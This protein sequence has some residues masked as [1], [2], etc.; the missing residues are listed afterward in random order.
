MSLNEENKEPETPSLEEGSK[1]EFNINELPEK[2]EKFGDI[3]LNVKVSLGKK[4]ISLGQ[5][6]KITRGSI[7]ELDTKKDDFVKIYINGKDIAEAD[8]IIENKDIL[9]KIE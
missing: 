7:L 2:L 5:F 6:L 8:I 3:K 9:V 1:Q 4:R